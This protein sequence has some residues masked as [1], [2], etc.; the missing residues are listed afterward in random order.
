MDGSRQLLGVFGVIGIVVFAAGGPIGTVA[1]GE[2]SQ[3]DTNA[4]VAR[5]SGTQFAGGIATEGVA[6]ENEHERR[7][8]N[9]SLERARTPAAR[10]GVINREESA[11]DKRLDSLEARTAR[12]ATDRRTGKIE[13]DQY[14]AESAVLKT[15]VSGITGRIAILRSATANLP[16]SQRAARG[17]LQ[18]EL[19]RLERRAH[20]VDEDNDDENVGD[21]DGADDLDE[22]DDNNEDPDTDDGDGD[23][24][25]DPDTDDDD[26]DD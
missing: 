2:L 6:L 20:A 1:S 15:E 4:S 17:S 21:D 14:R 13:R 8:L 26:D 23:D 18:N 25:E 5:S 7:T 11:L 22:D 24:K 10:T 12:L 3:V 9:E 19:D 16:R